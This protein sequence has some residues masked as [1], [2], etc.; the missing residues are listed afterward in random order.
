MDKDE[1]MESNE[2]NDKKEL[3]EIENELETLKCV[4][5]DL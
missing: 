1:K 3:N 4:F 2:A 5:P